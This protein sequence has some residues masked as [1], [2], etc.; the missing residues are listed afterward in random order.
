MFYGCPEGIDTPLS[1]NYYDLASLLGSCSV[2][3]AVFSYDFRKMLF[4]V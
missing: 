4:V 2:S 1:G 3:H